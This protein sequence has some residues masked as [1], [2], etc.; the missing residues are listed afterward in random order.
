MTSKHFSIQKQGNK[1]NRSNKNKFKLK[2]KIIKSRT[3]NKKKSLKI[4][5][6]KPKL[7]STNHM[8]HWPLW[9]KTKETFYQKKTTKPETVSKTREKSMEPEKEED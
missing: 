2:D 5:N 4:Y 9:F 3:H 8:Y 6:L 1:F 7:E